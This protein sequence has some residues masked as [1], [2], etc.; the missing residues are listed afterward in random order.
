MTNVT[1]LVPAR[2][3]EL[4]VE[5]QH[6]ASGLLPG[7]LK[8][9]LDK[10]DDT[11]FELANKADSSQRRNVYFDAMRELRLKRDTIERSFISNFNTGFENSIDLDKATK[12]APMFA[13]IMELSLVDPD[14][15]EESLALTNFTDSVKVNCKEQLF[16]LDR[17]MGYL[18][19]RPDLPNEMNPVGPLVI[20]NAFRD[21]FRQLDSDIEIKLTLFKIF[22]KFAAHSIH[23]MYCDIND[24]LIRRDVLPTIRSSVPAHSRSPVKTRVI[25]ETEGEQIEATGQDVFSTLQSLMGR[26]RGLPGNYLGR[27]GQQ[28]TNATGH[29]NSGSFHANGFAGSDSRTLTSLSA[30]G[31]ADL[32]SAL[33]LLQLGNLTSLQDYAVAGVDQTQIEAG[34]INVLRGLR[35]TGAFGNVN[36]TDGLTFDIVSILFDYILDDPAIP[37][38]MKA[39][40]GRLQIPMLKVAL[41]DKAL[42]SKK[43]HPARKLLDALASA[44][45]GWSEIGH[46]DD[47]LYEVIDLI[48]RR[49]VDEFQDDVSLFEKAL[50]DLEA[51]L[52]KDRDKTEKQVAESTRSLRTREQIVLAK[53]EVDDA[54]KDGVGDSEIRAFMRQFIFDYW[55]QLLIITH[56]EHGI[57]SEI[58]Q[59]QLRTVDDLIWSIQDKATPQ[60]RKA[61][62]E[63]LPQLLKSLKR[64]MAALDMDRA[65]CSKFMSMMASVHVVSV[66]RTQEASLAEKHLLG[67]AEEESDELLNADGETST[68]FMK[69]G[70]VRLFERKGVDS[71]ELTIDLSIF[72]DNTE[73]EQQPEN[74]S[75]EVR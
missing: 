73:F 57:R 1:R 26:G 21:A 43:A 17:R 56:V 15:V 33:T 8:T 64:G 35:E 61:L 28:N 52:I 27:A 2:S 29:A 44:A 75:A 50:A 6:L 30:T 46:A 23:Q 13:S 71:E 5:C 41:L 7:A 58:W 66:K 59:D 3:I 55:R 51:Y 63:R 22:D 10:V 32:I 72:D 49:I 9:V 14:E 31:T 16:G 37:D 25:I 74:L 19:S 54:L 24:H 42:F 70:L 45:V 4:L 48:V 62:S 69:Q 34:N 68:E 65:V 40:I 20:G 53:M 18:L 12:K 39:L 60:D 11:F 67:S 36:Q 38:A 47:K